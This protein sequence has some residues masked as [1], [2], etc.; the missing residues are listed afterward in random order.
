MLHTEGW[1]HSLQTRRGL[2]GRLP[3][4]PFSLGGFKDWS[5][6][7]HHACGISV[8][9]SEPH[10]SLFVILNITPEKEMS[11]TEIIWGDNCAQGT[12][13]G[14]KYE[15]LHTP[16]G[17]TDDQHAKPSLAFLKWKKGSHSKEQQKLRKYLERN[18]TM[19][20]KTF[21]RETEST[22]EGN[23]AFCIPQR[24]GSQ[25]RQD[26]I[27]PHIHQQTHCAL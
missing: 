7:L 20:C 22:C 18:L 13:Q 25:Q 23:R 8:L 19:L 14:S 11:S 16:L 26:D 2:T 5:Q 27:S 21:V 9:P 24:E 3:I 17:E 12:P 10:P 1:I 15:L 4:L 6:S